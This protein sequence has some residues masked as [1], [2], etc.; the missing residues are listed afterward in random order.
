LYEAG[1][2]AGTHRYG[3]PYGLVVADFDSDGRPDVVAANTRSPYISPAAISLLTHTHQPLHQQLLNSVTVG[4]PLNAIQTPSVA[5][6]DFNLDGRPDVVAVSNDLVSLASPVSVFQRTATGFAPP[7]SYS[8]AYGQYRLIAAGDVNADGLPDVVVGGIVD[9]TT[10]PGVMVMLSVI[11]DS[12]GPPLLY[13]LPTT[14][15]QYESDPRAMV[16]ADA[17]GDGIL[18][19][20]LAVASSAFGAPCLYILQGDNT[21]A[22]TT[23]LGPIA[24]EENSRGLVVGH[25]N[26]DAIPD[27]AVTSASTNRVSVHL[28]T[29]GGAFQAPVHHSVLT[30]P[31]PLCAGDIDG[32]ADLDLIALSANPAILSG[33]AVLRNNGNGTF[34]AAQ[35]HGGLPGSGQASL[36]DMDLDGYL[37]LVAT[38]N[39][40]GPDARGH[41]VGILLNDGTGG[42]LGSIPVADLGPSNREVVA[43]FN[44]DGRP[45]IAAQFVTS[46][47]L[48]FGNADGTFAAPVPVLTFTILDRL[49][50]GDVNRDGK[51]DLVIGGWSSQTFIYTGDGATSFVQQPGTIL[52]LPAA[53]HDLNRDGALDLIVESPGQM[54]PYIQNPATGLFAPK[55]PVAVSVGTKGVVVGDWNRD[56]IPDVAAAGAGGL[57]TFAMSPFEELGIET[58]VQGGRSYTAVCTGDF[59]RDGIPDLAAREDVPD[60]Q[61]SQ[62][63]VDVFLGTGTGAFT[64]ARSLGTLEPSGT[65]IASWDANLDGTPDLIASGISD[66]IGGFPPLS[67]FDLLLGSGGG[68]FGS[69]MSFSLG[70][71]TPAGPPQR[72]LT[73][74][75]VDRNRV[76]DVLATGPGPMGATVHSILA[77]P[78]AKGNGL[79]DATFYPTVA[80]P[81]SV[82]VGDLNRDGRPD[83][84]TAAFGTNPGVAVHLG[85]GLGALGGSAILAQSWN[86]GRVGLADFNRDGILDIAAAN[87]GFGAPRVS[88]MLGVG[89]GTFG[90]RNDYFILAGNEFEVGD[91]NRDGIPDVVT[92]AQDSIRVLHGTGTGTFTA[93]PGVEIGGVIYDLDLADLNRDGFLD[94]A[95]ANQVIKIVYGGAGTLSAPITLAAPITA[96]QTLCVADFNRDGFPDIATNS[97]GNYYVLWGENA[98]PF[99]S[100][101]TTNLPFAASDMRA[102]DAEANGT[103]YLYISRHVPLLEVVS[104]SP[105]GALAVVGSYAV[106]GAPSQF[107]LGDLDHDGGLDVVTIGN[108]DSMVSVNLHGF[109]VITAVDA[110][111]PGVGRAM[112]RQNHP[113][114]FNPR[115]TIRYSVPRA[116]RA[117]LAVFDVNGRL[118][119]TLR[120]GPMSAGEH[121]VE[122]DGRNAQGA[123]VASGVYLYRLSTESGAAESRKMV[124]AK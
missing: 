69:R 77:T 112:L 124:V 26:A 17:T 57:A 91:M 39:G 71:L 75:D 80:S 85:T 121:E 110:P 62:R 118:V 87:S 7:K 30:Q 8:P 32:D 46:V 5:T 31:G 105:A 113:N 82:A 23:V 73:L 116:E 115:T 65:T 92:V 107:A 63:G 54:A 123:Q 29:G 25:F 13:P 38:T 50:A 67:S 55:A 52:G 6:A 119:T 27:I 22:F 35:I 103:S 101:A 97:S 98:A 28:G 68:D 88:T 4:G 66:A 48:S 60:I 40:G 19:V 59:N 20:V 106:A 14:S 79:R 114:P 12:L 93:G 49:L 117:R 11:G 51:M 100:Y 44:R 41:T 81:W 76:P 58:L 9:I 78:P 34:A 99:S 42:F 43:D 89:D 102:G 84:V 122:W 111:A 74:A 33:V 53:L 72:T 36:A 47:T 61:T 64:F 15:Y 83:V 109:G 37:D 70:A 96:G 56:G 24:T 95:V 108:D 104:V 86:S 16:L 18:D 45:D 90:P 21:G 10:M 3:S 94:I 120:D 2:N 1:Y